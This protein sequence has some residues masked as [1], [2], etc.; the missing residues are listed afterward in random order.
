M[1][2][3]GDRAG[4]KLGK[5]DYH[6]GVVIFCDLGLVTSEETWFKYNSMFHQFQMPLHV[7]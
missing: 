7:R 4:L 6:P 3:V 2:V 1:C 5:V